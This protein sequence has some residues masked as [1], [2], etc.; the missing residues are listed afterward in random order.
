MAKP[1]EDNATIALMAKVAKD[2]NVALPVS[3]FEKSNKAYFN[4]IAMVDSDGTILGKYRK[5]HIP[6]GVGYQEKFYFNPGIQALKFGILSFVKFVSVYV[7]I[8]GFQRLHA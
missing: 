3:F 8:N 5:S 2:N 4:T 1:F 6:D 7:G